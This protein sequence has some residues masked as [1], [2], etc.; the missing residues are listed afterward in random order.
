MN[1]LP[2]LPTG[3]ENSGYVPYRTPHYASLAGL[4]P[5]SDSTSS[6]DSFMTQVPYPYHHAPDYQASSQRRSGLDAPAPRPFT[7]VPLGIE[8]PSTS[9]SNAPRA[10]DDPNMAPGDGSG[11]NPNSAPYIPTS[12]A[13]TSST[14]VM[15]NGSIRQSFESS[16]SYQSEGYSRENSVSSA[17]ST[18]NPEYGTS[19]CDGSQYGSQGGAQGGAQ[20]GMP[21][22]A[23]GAQ[24][25]GQN[26]GSYSASNQ[27]FADQGDF[28]MGNLNLGNHA[29][30]F[31]LSNPNMGPRSP[32]Y[33][34][35]G[36]NMGRSTSYGQ[37][38]TNYDHHN[39][40]SSNNHRGG[41]ARAQSYATNSGPMGYNNSFPSPAMSY[42]N[43]DSPNQQAAYIGGGGNSTGVSQAWGSLGNDGPAYGRQNANSHNNGP[44]RGY[45]GHTAS[46]FTFNNGSQNPSGYG[47][48]RNNYIQASNVPE[49]QYGGSQ[50][51]DSQYSTTQYDD[52]SQ[53][54]GGMHG[55]GMH[56]GGYCNNGFARGNSGHGKLFNNR[57]DNRR[58]RGGRVKHAARR[59]QNPLTVNDNVA[60]PIAASASLHSTGYPAVSE[61]SM[62]S[63]DTKVDGSADDATPGPRNR[64]SA[65]MPTAREKEETPKRETASDTGA[66]SKQDS[67]SQWLDSTPT[68]QMSLEKASD[69][70]K[71]LQRQAAPPKMS[72]LQGAS[73]AMMSPLTPVNNDD[74]FVTT[75]LQ[76]TGFGMSGHPGPPRPYEEGMIDWE[77]GN[78]SPELRSL[79]NDGTTAKPNIEVA[80]NPDVL[81]LVEY[82][83]LYKFDNHGVIKITNVSP[84]IF[85]LQQSSANQ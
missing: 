57:G 82:C 40:S 32:Q 77:E 48:N 1:R 58:G 78:P 23:Y 4:N 33:G 15:A 27:S 76:P 35:Q 10:Q 50:Y 28:G 7:L 36:Q 70:V 68:N 62:M 9:N 31:R 53:Y 20:Y 83:R 79:T 66:E 71:R 38:N 41:H 65:S 72:D 14:F 26:N 74:V 55:G 73:T 22:Q 45:G 56:G 19:Y 34:M 61:A 16:S 3:N 21:S 52:G 67:V 42:G 13:Q 64:N 24:V 85:R 63:G 51:G 18:N 46:A 43:L 60:T 6:C 8:L 30:Q 80:L 75:S 59:N 11:L 69:T 29:P 39:N 2:I 49:S 12:F 81:P 54:G 84:L 44:M 37:P 25:Y 5:N 17:A 47:N